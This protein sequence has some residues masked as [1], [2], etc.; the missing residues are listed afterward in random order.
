MLLKMRMDEDVVFQ[1]TTGVECSSCG[2]SVLY[3]QCCGS[4]LRLDNSI[5]VE[6]VIR[7]NGKSQ[8]V[9]S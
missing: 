1:A 4:E 8:I 6:S 2:G 9:L 5:M 3:S 7:D